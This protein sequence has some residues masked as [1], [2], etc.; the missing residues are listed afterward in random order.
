LSRQRLFDAALFR[1]QPADADTGNAEHHLWN[2]QP[3][4]T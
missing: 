3:Y 2:S 1:I 4:C